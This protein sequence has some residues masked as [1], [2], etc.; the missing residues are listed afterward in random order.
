MA[1]CTCAPAP[2]VASSSS[3]LCRARDEASNLDDVQSAYAGLELL[4]APMGS[5]DAEEI[6]AS[7]TE[8]SALVR[9]VNEE[10]DRRMPGSPS[11]VQDSVQGS[12]P[13]PHGLASHSLPSNS[14]RDN[15][16]LRRD[17]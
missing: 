13:F 7:R 4:I 5:E 16:L 15:N 2:S 14:L 12:R 6:Q 8:L 1:C 3:F 10:F 17:L 11:R 9:L